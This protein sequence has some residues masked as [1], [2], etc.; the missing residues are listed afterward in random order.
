MS[1]TAASM[2]RFYDT[3][4]RLHRI[5]PGKAVSDVPDDIPEAATLKGII[6][7]FDA[8]FKLAMDDDFNTA[9][10]VGLVFESVRALNR[11]LDATGDKPTAF[12]GWVVLQFMHVQHVADEVLGVFGSSDEEYRKRS[13]GRAKASKGVDASRVETLIE[14]RKAARKSKNFARSDEIRSELAS[15]GIEIKDRPDGTTEW[16]FKC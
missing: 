4:E 2:N 15:L 14:E 10:A 9:R 1:D 5:H 6:E 11:Y 16:K 8:E 13:A 7:K 3:V 12:A